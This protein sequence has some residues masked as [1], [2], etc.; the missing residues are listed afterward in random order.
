MVSGSDSNSQPELNPYDWKLLE[1]VETCQ[2][3]SCMENAV[4]ECDLNLQ[5]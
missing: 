3:E 5:F 2:I 1:P 4:C